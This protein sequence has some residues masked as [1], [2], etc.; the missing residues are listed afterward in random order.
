MNELKN[1]I[2]RLER[3]DEDKKGIQDDINEVMREMK[4]KGFDLKAV[5]AVLRLRKMD[6]ADREELSYLTDE[7]LKLLDSGL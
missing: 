5:R 4:N 3:L 6:P 1:Y 2:D 7:Y